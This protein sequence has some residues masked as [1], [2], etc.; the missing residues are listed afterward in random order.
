MSRKPPPQRPRS[1]GADSRSAIARRMPPPSRAPSRAMCTAVLPVRHFPARQEP[2]RASYRLRITVA[3]LCC[4]NIS[5]PRAAHR[6]EAAALQPDPADP[7]HPHA[8]MGMGMGILILCTRRTLRDAPRR[9]RFHRLLSALARD[10]ML[11]LIVRAVGRSGCRWSLALA[12]V[13][14]VVVLRRAVCRRGARHRT[15]HSGGALAMKQSFGSSP[16][17]LSG[18]VAW[19]EAAV[20]QNCRSGS[21]LPSLVGMVPVC[22]VRDSGTGLTA[23]LTAGVA[24]P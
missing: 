5:D 9:R 18:E 13:V 8:R 23:C 14:V 19:E 11:G 24:R 21:L 12:L 7:Q 2:V 1:R 20:G 3:A 22:P 10:W 6:P 15:H 4:A 16:A 17:S